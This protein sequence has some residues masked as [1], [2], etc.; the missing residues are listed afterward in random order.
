MSSFT[1]TERAFIDRHRVARLAT[2][3][4]QG[5]PHLIP[6]VYASVGAAVYFIID[7]KPKRSRTSLK[8]LRNIEQNSQVAL[9]F[10]DYDEDWTCLAY[11]LIHGR[12]AVVTHRTEYSRALKALRDRYPQ[13]RLMPLAFDSHPLVRI[14]RER[15]HLWKADG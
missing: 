4:L 12:A 2:S 14:T 5:A 10:D 13:Y 7:D 3:D 8:R 11:L 1:R 9:L 6:I 15:G